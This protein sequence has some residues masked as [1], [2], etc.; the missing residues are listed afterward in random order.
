MLA[1]ASS[2]DSTRFADR[3]RRDLTFTMPRVNNTVMQHGL[4]H[5]WLGMNGLK[6][7]A[8]REFVTTYN[9]KKSKNLKYFVLDT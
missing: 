8:L 2:T 5:Y 3:K 1:F 4:P 7:N 9:H 6:E